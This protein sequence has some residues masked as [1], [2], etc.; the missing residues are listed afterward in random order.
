[1][2]WSNTVDLRLKVCFLKVSDLIRCC[3]FQMTSLAFSTNFN[4]EISTI[5]QWFCYVIPR[6]RVDESQ[7][8]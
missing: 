1:M 8:R 5:A 3:Q 2:S 7:V 4:Q 6:K